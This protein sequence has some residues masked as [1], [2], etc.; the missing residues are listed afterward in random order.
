[1]ALEKH[2]KSLDAAKTA[3]L[4][5]RETIRKDLSGAG[6][7][8][9]LTVKVGDTSIQANATVS[10]KDGRIMYNFS[11]AVPIT[12]QDGT[13]ETAR[14]GGNIF[15]PYTSPQAREEMEKAKAMA[16]PTSAAFK[17]AVQAQTPKA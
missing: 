15:L 13:T 1:M 6:F 16:A 2:T 8:T 10:V 14:V 17:A 12:K 11:G 3:K 7:P 4:Q 5:A 9:S